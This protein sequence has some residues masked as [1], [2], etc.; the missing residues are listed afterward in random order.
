VRDTAS[1][2]PESHAADLVRVRFA[3]NRIGTRT[4][5]SAPAREA[6]YGEIE[7]APEE[8]HRAALAD[9]ARAELAEHAVERDQDAPEAFG[10]DA[11]VARMDGVALE[12]NRTGHFRRRRVDADLDSGRGEHVHRLAVEVGNAHRDERKA[13]RAAVA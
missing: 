10:I 8:M 11:I 3:G 13:S 7:A 12:R 1:T 4:L 6:R 2:R 9:E 5:G